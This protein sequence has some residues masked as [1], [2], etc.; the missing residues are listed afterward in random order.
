[1][2]LLTVRCMKQQCVSGVVVLYPAHQLDVSVPHDGAELTQVLHHPVD[3]LS[4]ALLLVAAHFLD[5]GQFHL[6]CHQVCL[7]EHRS[8]YN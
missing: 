1:M 4:N 7:W 3:S 5:T 8:R 6:Q 2:T